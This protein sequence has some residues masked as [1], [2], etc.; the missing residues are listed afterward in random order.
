MCGFHLP[1]DSG[2]SRSYFVL[3]GGLAVSISTSGQTVRGQT[4]LLPIDRLSA[5]A[6]S[7]CYRRY[8]L[9]FLMLVLFGV[10]QIALILQVETLVL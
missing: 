9:V 10:A 8:R 6:L 3:A 1:R 7:T 2:V 5:A 4:H